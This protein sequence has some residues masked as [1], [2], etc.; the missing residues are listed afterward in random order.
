MDGKTRR[1]IRKDLTVLTSVALL[2]LVGLSALT[3]TGY[4]RSRGD[5]ARWTT[6]MR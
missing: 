2:G 1:T 4:G 3:G 5:P 6:H